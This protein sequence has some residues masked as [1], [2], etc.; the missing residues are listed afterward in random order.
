MTGNFLV[1]HDRKM[2]SYKFQVGLPLIGEIVFDRDSIK[3]IQEQMEKLKVAATPISTLQLDGIQF[4]DV[5]FDN[6]ADL[7]QR[8]EIIISDMKELK[9]KADNP[10]QK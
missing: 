4:S 6:L 7:I 9:A 5:P 1:D 3:K 10:P 8:F 2:V